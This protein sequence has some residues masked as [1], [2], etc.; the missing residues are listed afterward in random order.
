MSM[1]LKIDNVTPVANAETK[2]EAK[3]PVSGDFE[4]TLK[5]LGDE[6]LAQRL[7]KLM[8]DITA[9]GDKL[10]R[11]MD[12]KD[13]RMYRAMIT[14]FINEIVTNAYRFSRENYLNRRGIHVVY[15]VVRLINKDLDDLAQELLKDE[16]NH[17]AILEKTGEIQ[18]LL[19][20]LLI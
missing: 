5:R 20:D 12:I 14:E 8:T 9:Q 19:L 1:D 2:T 7:E 17:L 4:F 16:K 15:S 3:K 10:T 11:H 6:G 13:M 18:G